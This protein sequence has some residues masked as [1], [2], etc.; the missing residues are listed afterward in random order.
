MHYF[1]DFTFYFLRVNYEQG[2]R[3]QDA[4]VVTQPE[5]VV[6]NSFNDYAFRESE[7][8]NLI[9]S[10]RKW[11]GDSFGFTSKEILIFLFQIVMA[12]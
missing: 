5:N 6:V 7:E 11:Y 2:L 1:S 4:A 10:G 8:I 9:K 3:V 12:L